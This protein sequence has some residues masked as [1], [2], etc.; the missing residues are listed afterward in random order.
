MRPVDMIITGVAVL[1]IGLIVW[2]VWSSAPAGTAAT[3]PNAV[4]ASLLKN[5]TVAP[6]FT[7]PGNDG[8]TYTLSQ[9]K[10]KPVF[11]EFM[12]PWCP[13][14]QADAP[15]F[16]QVY[17]SYKDKVAMLGVNASPYGHNYENND[18]SPIT[19]AD[20]TW[21]RDNF[22]VQYPLLFDQPY[23][24][25]AAGRLDTA[26]RVAFGI[27]YFPTVY[28]ID[29]D[30]KIF[31]HVMADTNSAITFERVAAILDNALK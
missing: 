9:F 24:D 12:A 3:D 22:K 4:D 18:N 8:K 7:L 29:K 10:G 15:I 6:D 5:G 25:Q 28:I 17:D 11:V 23:N 20:L 27:E 16:N 30:G 26:Q 13:H 14:C 31:D 1:V 19:M 2:A 21:F